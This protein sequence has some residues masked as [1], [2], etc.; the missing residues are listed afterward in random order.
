M[1]SANSEGLRLFVSLDKFAVFI[2]WSEVAVSGERSSPATTVRLKIA[3]VPDVSLEF[4][5]DDAAADA[6]FSGVMTPL[7]RRDPPGRIYWPKSWAVGVLV[8]SMIAAAC[9]L[10][11]LR[12]SWLVHVVVGCILAVAIAVVWTVCRPVF[13]EEG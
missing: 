4:H 7:P 6:L 3:K 13:E 1:L 5:L 8:G 2:P 9:V 12:L 10:A 11:A